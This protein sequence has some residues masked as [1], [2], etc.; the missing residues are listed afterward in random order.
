MSAD[1]N[2]GSS[3]VKKNNNFCKNDDKWWYKV[4][5]MEITALSNRF[6]FRGRLPKLV[7]GYPVNG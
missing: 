1:I 3:G 5:N 6:H 7:N 4:K 2:T